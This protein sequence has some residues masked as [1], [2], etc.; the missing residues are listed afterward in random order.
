ML[1][2]IIDT[3]TKSTKYDPIEKYCNDYSK[4]NWTRRLV[5]CREIRCQKKEESEVHPRVSRLV[6]EFYYYIVAEPL[7]MTTRSLRKKENEIGVLS[8]S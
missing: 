7:R 4:N 2:N 1:Q 6:D 5:S 8:N 3:Q